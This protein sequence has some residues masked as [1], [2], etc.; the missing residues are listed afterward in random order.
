VTVDAGTVIVGNANAFGTGPIT[1]AGGT[2][3]WFAASYTVTNSIIAQAG[4]SSA[5]AEQGAYSTTFSGNLSGSG[6]IYSS[7]SVNF[8][9]AQ[10]SG[11]NS[12]YSG[13]LTVN[14][15]SSQR[16]R[17]LSATAGSSNAVWVLNNNTTD[18]QSAN[19]GNGTLYFG[20]L[21]GYGQCRQDTA[22]TTTLE[23]GALNLDTTFSGIFNQANGSCVFALNKVGTGTLT[24][25]GANTYT[26]LNAVK[27]G[28]LLIAQ[29][30][31][32]NGG[33][34][35]SSNATLGFANNFSA[36]VAALGALTLA[37]GATLEFQ[38]VS[39]LTSAL[40]AA[41]TV[42]VNGSGTVL[43]TGTNYLAAGNTYPLLTYSGSFVGTFTNLQLQM[44]YGWRGTL[45]QVGQQIVLTNVAVV[46]TTSPQISV[47]P[48]SQQFQF[49]WPATHTGWRLEVQT[50]SL[51]AG[52]GTNWFTVP[53]STTTNQVVVP[54]NP[55]SG[56]IFYRL[57]YP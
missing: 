51:A 26:G 34:T 24:L 11:N 2:L 16:F 15:G 52:L 3:A 30:F 37:A 7:A 54:R 1:L 21:A 14:N 44:P 17:F 6:D 48:G 23:I 49:A 38:N 8:G 25:S 9:G 22:G 28:R 5:F 47:T 40:A 10:L 27:R 12:G 41:T 36:S 29:A 18:G 57:V 56:S 53:G 33:F 13:T 35:V 4:T 31:A 39:N 46:A 55:T 32:G 50:N 45:A 42:T 43:I 19:F 20:A